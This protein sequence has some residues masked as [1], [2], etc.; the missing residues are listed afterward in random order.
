MNPNHYHLTDQEIK[1]VYKDYKKCY[2]LAY[3]QFIKYK[4]SKLPK[5]VQLII[6]RWLRDYEEL[7]RFLNGDVSNEFIN[8]TG[9]NF[10]HAGLMDKLAILLK[11]KQ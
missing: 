9:I 8:S 3:L 7:S 1:Q 2:D 6:Y 5:A 4:E 10:N 11:K